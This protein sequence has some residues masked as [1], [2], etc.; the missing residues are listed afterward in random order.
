MS[1]KLSPMPEYPTTNYVPVGDSDVAYQVVGDGACDMLCVYPLGTHLDLVWSSPL[2][3]KPLSVLAAN[4]RVILLDRRGTGASGRLTGTTMPTWEKLSEDILAVLDAA[5]S[6]RTAI[7]GSV[8]TGP[9]AVLF[10]AMHPE[11]VS[12]LTL[13]T[14][15]ARYPQAP[16][17]PIGVPHDMAEGALELLAKTWGTEELARL[18]YPSASDPDVLRQAA[19]LHRAS[20]TPR[21]AVAQYRYFIRNVDVREVLPLVRV[22]TLVVHSQDSALIPISHGRYLAEHIPGAR[23]VERP[24][25]DVGPDDEAVGLIVEFVTGTRPSIE[26][27]RVLTTLVFTDIVSSTERAAALGDL[28]WRGLLDAHDRVVREQLRRFRGREVNT[29]GDGF[30]ASFD[31]PAR[32]IRCGREIVEAAASLGVDVRVGVHC[33]ECEVR[34]A[35]L[36]GLSVHVGARIGALAEAGEVLVSQ[37]V[38]DLVSGSGI[39]FQH[40]GEHELKG[41]PGSWEL[42]AVKA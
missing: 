25:G 34:G 5:G 32:A 31:G 7:M 22:P 42:F 26:A 1:A 33:G 41:V 20:A 4:G 12:S 38:K 39:E 35:D 21:E 24:G 27:D 18:L 16:D 37:M 30:L 40:R 10:A 6:T 15:T 19:L 28:R 17:Y 13:R 23:L 9:I 14:T 29:T 11:R 2:H 36:G 8:E 3:A